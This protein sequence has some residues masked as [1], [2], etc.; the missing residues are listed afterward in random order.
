MSS[1][2]VHLPPKP[3]LVDY[4][5]CGTLKP[6]S[7]RE[8][9]RESV[10]VGECESISVATIFPFAGSFH[11]KRSPSLSE[12]GFRVCHSKGRQQSLAS[13]AMLVLHTHPSLENKFPIAPFPHK[14]RLK[15]LVPSLLKAVRSKQGDKS[16]ELQISVP[17]VPRRLYSI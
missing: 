5:K 8:V 11:R 17:P 3:S 1:Q 7:E 6:P 15:S 2:K 16:P 4:L 12:G 9:A 10:T 14:G 13:V